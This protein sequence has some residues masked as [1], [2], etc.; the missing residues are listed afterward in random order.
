MGINNLPNAGI[1]LCFL[2]FAL[3]SCATAPSQTSAP[4][5]AG[6]L[7]EGSYINVRVPNSDGW[8]LASASTAGMAFARSGVEQGASFGAQA[9][10]FPL[11]ETQREEEFVTLIKTSLEADTD[12]ARFPSVKSDYEYSEDRKYPCV[13]VSSV[14]EDNQAKTSKSHG[15]EKLILQSYALYCRHPAHQGVGFA[16][17]YSRRGPAQYENLSSEALDF[18]SGVQ[19][20][21]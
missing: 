15:S 1:L 3:A 17:I 13:K 19:V 16:A 18:I 5:P 2:S 6:Y 21:D 12:P 9:L 14:A 4:L 7:Y 8:H 20:P 10:V 11:P